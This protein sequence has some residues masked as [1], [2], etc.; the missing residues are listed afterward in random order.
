MSDHWE[1]FPCTMGENGGDYDGWE[2]ELRRMAR[3]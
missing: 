1:T 3:S 2:T